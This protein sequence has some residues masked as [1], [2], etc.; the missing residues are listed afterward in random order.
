VATDNVVPLFG[1]KL[2]PR[3]LPLPAGV[4]NNFSA[5]VDKHDYAPVHLDD[6]AE[7]CGF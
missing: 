5:G 1:P 4:N 3:R 6:L 7:E 2:F